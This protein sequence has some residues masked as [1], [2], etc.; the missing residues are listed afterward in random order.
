LGYLT[1]RDYKA[2]LIIFNKHNSKFSEILDKIPN[3]LKEHPQIKKF[4]GQKDAGE[5]D[6]VFMSKEDEARLVYVRVFIFDIYHKP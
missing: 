5:W 4:S 1:W 6:F 3:I 2:A